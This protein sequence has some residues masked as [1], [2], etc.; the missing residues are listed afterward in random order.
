MDQ[1]KWLVQLGAS[2]ALLALIDQGRKRGSRH[3]AYA[4]TG[5]CNGRRSVIAALTFS[6]K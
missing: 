1:V 6:R 4:I 5:R 2:L 3:L